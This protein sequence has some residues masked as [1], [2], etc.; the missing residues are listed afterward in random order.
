[1]LRYRTDGPIAWAELDRPEKL[2]AMTR[3][4]WQELRETLARAQDD[5]GVRVLIFHGAGTSFC[6]GGDI[7]AF[8][9]LIDAADK[10]AYLND[11]VGALESVERF[12]KPTIAAV[13]GYCMGG[14]CELTIACDIVIA[15]STARF[16]T[17][18][19]AVGLFPGP[20]VARGAAHV[21]LHW[22][23][24]MVFTGEQ[25][26]AEEARLAGL[27][28]RVTPEGEHLLAAEAIARTI[29]ERAPLALSV[30][31]QVINRRYGEGYQHAIDAV[32]YLQGT[33]DFAE[34]IEAFQQ[35]RQP[36]F[37]GR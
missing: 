2:N 26:C 9:D 1:M 18:E 13:H 31:K 15:D 12:S 8:G 16:A 17:P 33:D 30:G 21:N 19:A 20:G 28:N 4:V 7:V 23:K 32:A 10:R 14:G 36:Q 3:S 25:L 22:L 29:S 5:S 6:V 27:V 35:R 34:G 37:K 24:F 11:A